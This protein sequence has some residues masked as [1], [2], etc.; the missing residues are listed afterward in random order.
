MLGVVPFLTDLAIPEEDA[1]A[2]DARALRGECKRLDIA[3]IRLPHIANF[4]D[5]DP[6]AQEPD[7]RAATCGCRLFRADVIV[8]PAPHTAPW[9]GLRELRAREAQCWRWRCAS[10]VFCVIKP[11]NFRLPTAN[12]IR[13]PGEA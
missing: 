3:V 8:A 13:Y 9:K 6:L 7:V 11:A 2:L 5:F 4:D 1:V 10:L 12:A